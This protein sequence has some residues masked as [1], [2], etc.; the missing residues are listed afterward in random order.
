M[1][2][3]ARARSPHRSTAAKSARCGSPS[4]IL[5]TCRSLIPHLEQ[6]K[7]LF[8][9]LEFKFLRGSSR[10]VGEFLKKGEAELGIA[11]EIGEDW[12]R[13]DSLAAVH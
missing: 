9:R 6:I 5:S 10:E 2:R 12:D 8:N 1:P 13:L 7:R 4:P 11:A 3:P